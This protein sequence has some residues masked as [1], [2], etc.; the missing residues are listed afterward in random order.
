MGTQERMH[1]RVKLMGFMR[2]LEGEVVVGMN[3]C[4]DGPN[5]CT[6]IYP[7]GVA[8]LCPWAEPP[9]L[10]KVTQKRGRVSKLKRGHALIAPHVVVGDPRFSHWD[11]LHPDRRSTYDRSMGCLAG[12]CNT[13]HTAGR[14][15]L[16]TSRQ[17]GFGRNSQGNH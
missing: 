11:A 10:S 12:R 8:T 2:G 4:V 6:M 17:N 7:N 16:G 1:E 5:S 14:A 3:G 13:D 9:V 15:C